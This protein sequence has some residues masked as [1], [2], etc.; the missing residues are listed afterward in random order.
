MVLNIWEVMKKQL[1]FHK[2]ILQLKI[3]MYL[4]DDSSSSINTG[5]TIIEKIESSNK[6]ILNQTII[7][8]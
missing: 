5:I 8:Q 7:K 1:V 4:Y 2:Q 6:I 3:G